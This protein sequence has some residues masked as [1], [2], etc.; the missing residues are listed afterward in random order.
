MMPLYTRL[1]LVM[2]ITE[3]SRIAWRLRFE[4]G[5]GSMF[6]H[7]KSDRLHLERGHRDIIFRSPIRG[8]VRERVLFSNI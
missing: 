7:E 1:S 5:R 4:R 2:L 3:K 8:L 6:R